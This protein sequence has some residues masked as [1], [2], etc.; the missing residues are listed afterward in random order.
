[1]ETGYTK[2]TNSTEVDNYLPGKYRWTCT[3]CGGLT[4]TT[5]LEDD[6]KV[7][8]CPKHALASRHGVVFEVVRKNVTA[9]VTG[10]ASPAVGADSFIFEVY[11]FEAMPGEGFPAA[12]VKR[13]AVEAEYGDALCAK[14]DAE[15][16]AYQGAGA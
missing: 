14:W 15:E 11:R 13:V 9:L 16:E 4:L 3:L 2:E 8:D 7:V 5:D 1:M 12:R 10:G 6:T